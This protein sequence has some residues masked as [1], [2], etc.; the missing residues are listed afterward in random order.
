MAG[1][2]V[3]DTCR[4][5]WRVWH[6]LHRQWLG[7]LV[8]RPVRHEFVG[9]GWSLVHGLLHLDVACQLYQESSL[10][11]AWH[12]AWR[13]E[14]CV[15]CGSVPLP[16]QTE[17]VATAFGAAWSLVNLPPAGF[18]RAM[19]PDLDG[20]GA[21]LA[22]LGPLSARLHRQRRQLVRRARRLAGRLRR[23]AHT[24]Q[25]LA[26][27]C[28]IELLRRHPL[29]GTLGPSSYTTASLLVHAWYESGQGREASDRGVAALA[30][31]GSGPEVDDVLRDELDV[32]DALWDV[33]VQVVSP[34]DRRWVWE[35]LMGAWTPNRA[36]SEH[37][38][39]VPLPVAVWMASRSE[40]QVFVARPL[41]ELVVRLALHPSVTLRAAC[42]TA[43]A[44]LGSR[45]A[46]ALDEP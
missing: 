16:A 23:L 30:L 29:L 10:S 31:G 18:V 6:S 2:D 41:H 36:G 27:F 9:D 24:E 20:V 13:L 40:V 38:W 39:K 28:R 21:Q 19:L 43:A 1:R 5:V 42:V 26:V 11:G 32:I 8:G 44:S 25:Q 4:T 22:A 46:A 33:T 37:H 14:R 3:S 15:C 45:G 17:R 35:D 7:R 12:L 34:A